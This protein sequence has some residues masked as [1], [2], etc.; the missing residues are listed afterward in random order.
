[1]AR[2]CVK[3][4][5]LLIT[6]NQF[7]ICLIIFAKNFTFLIQNSLQLSFTPLR[8]VFL[9]RISL[10]QWNDPALGGM[11]CNGKNEFISTTFK[12]VGADL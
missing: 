1:M 3:F 11:N 8:P 10:M 2:V 7:G 4:I 5:S 12:N 6:T 9:L